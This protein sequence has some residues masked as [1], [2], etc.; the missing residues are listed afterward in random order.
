VVF[1]TAGHIDHGKTTLVRALTGRDTDRLPEEKARGIS[2][3]L[4][5]APLTLP[6]GR[7]AAFVDV[8]GHERFVRNMVAGV[9]G[10]DA[11]M[12][13]VAATEGVMPQTVEHLAILDFLGLSHGL[14]ALT[15]ADLVEADWLELVEAD[16]REALEGSFMAAAPILPVAAPTGQGVAEVRRELDR[17]AAQVPKRDASGVLRLP[18]DRV[19]TIRGF[20]TVVTGTLTRGSLTVDDAV[21]L[22][23]AGIAARVRGL[24]SHGQSVR[25]VAAGQRVAV[26]LA[27]VN[28]GDVERGQVLT[29]PGQLTSTTVAAVRLTLLRGAAPIRHRAR[30]HVHA[31][32][33]EVLARV[34]F[35]DREALS[36]G[37]AW[38]ELRF[39]RPVVIQRG[40]RVLVRT[41]SPVTTAGG[42][43]VAEVGVHHRRREENLLARMELELS[44]DPVA[45]AISRVDARPA[46]MDVSELARSVGMA[47]KDLWDALQGHPEAFLLDPRWVWTASARDRMAEEL[48]RQVRAYQRDRPLRPGWPRERQKA[49]FPGFDARLF[50]QLVEGFP[51]LVLDGE[52]VRTPDFRVEVAGQAEESRQRILDRLADAGLEPPEVKDL[53]RDLAGDEESRRDLLEWLVATGELVRV[54]E[55]LVV[56]GQAYREAVDRVRAAIRERGPLGTAELRD[57]LKTSRKFAVPL[58]ERMDDDRVTR[59]EGDVRVLVGS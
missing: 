3:D 34:Y 39:E 22:L 23:P 54:D 18:I 38:A 47:P 55:N 1:G 36:G 7:T 14:V 13:V 53:L 56:S 31:G 57:C 41:Y 35:W 59:R 40:D 25:R 30:V 37:E 51:A 2:I 49:S 45:I 50:G 27:G 24:E 33:A 12:L 28:R 19:F 46:P 5:F 26:N 21:E 20:G 9:H 16:T 42:G 4:G 29:R 8:P 52:F 32:T 6:S 10:M 11:V 43:M 44:G 48:L 15:K 58:L 17:M